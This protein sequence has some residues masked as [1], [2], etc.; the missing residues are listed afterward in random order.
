M[1]KSTV[2]PPSRVP[3]AHQICCS[4]LSDINLTAPSANST[5]TPPGCRLLGAIIVSNDSQPASHERWFG[6][7]E[8]PKPDPRPPLA[9]YQTSPLKSQLY[10]L[11]ASQPTSKS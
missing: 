6:R 4:T 1:V 9:Q 3:I 10:E 11:D 5:F 8:N 7:F 2:S